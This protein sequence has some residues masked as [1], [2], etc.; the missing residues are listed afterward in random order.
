MA[1]NNRGIARGGEGLKRRDAVKLAATAA[2]WK[3][4]A[5]D[6]TLTEAGHIFWAMD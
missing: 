4:A 5:A 3:I 2:E 6:L 1:V